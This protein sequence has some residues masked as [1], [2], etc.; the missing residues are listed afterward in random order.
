MSDLMLDVRVIQIIELTRKKTH[1]SLDYL[2][3]ELGVST[4]TIR[5]D[6][7]QLNSDLNGIA[8][9]ENVKGKGYRLT[10]KDELLFE[11]LVEKINSDKHLSDSPQSR[12]AYII[13]QLVNTDK[14]ST[15]DELA[16]EMNIGRTTLVNE[17]KKLQ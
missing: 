13:D 4:R 12:I 17:L 7:K 11:N 10:I 3:E 1:C 8:A 9:L 6:I 2:S 15:L 16:F 5:N 14:V